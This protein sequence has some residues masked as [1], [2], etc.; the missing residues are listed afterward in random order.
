[1]SRHDMSGALVKGRVGFPARRAT[2]D[3]RTK[4]VVD[5]VA[6]FRM[7]NRDDGVP[8]H[9][10]VVA[11]LAFARVLVQAGLVILKRNRAA[12]I[13]IVGSYNHEEECEQ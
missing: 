1:M 2:V 10:I 12:W 11:V 4:G 7:V 9:G 5:V 6:V 3:Q 13:V 8:V